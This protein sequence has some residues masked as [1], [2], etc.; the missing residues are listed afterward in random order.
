[1]NVKY[2]DV[3]FVVPFLLQLWMFLSP[4]IYPS[5]F[6]PP[7]LRQVLSFNPMTGII[8][9]Y[10]SSLFGLAFNW[11]SLGL[12][13]VIVLVSLVYASFSFRRMEKNFADL[14]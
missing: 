5:S 12:S 14:I 11:G 1:V 13:L 10:R 8:E 2:R 7:T 3:R 9:G 6:L 4:V